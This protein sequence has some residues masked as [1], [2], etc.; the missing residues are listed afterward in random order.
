MKEKILI[1][2]SLNMDIVVSLKNMPGLGET[3]S[4]Y[5]LTYIPGGKGANQAYAAGKLSGDVSMLGCVGNDEFGRI[6]LANLKKAGVNITKLKVSDKNPTGTAIIY[7]NEMGDNSIVIISGANGECDVEYLKENDDLFRWCDYVILQM[8]IPYESVLYSI[9]RANRLE[10][11]IILNPAPAPEELPD[12]ILKML[13][14]ITPNE[15]ELMKLTDCECKNLE[16]YIKASRKLLKRGAKNVLVT[17]GEQGA[18]LVNE[19]TEK[20][21]PARKVESVDTT[22]AG[23]CFNAALT[24]G[25]AD[26]MDEEEAIFFANISSSVA[27]TRKGAQSSLPDRTEIDRVIRNL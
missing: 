24:V 6:Q 22:A 21:Y 27:V 8:E 10:K 16:D 12:D 3:V 4:G 20:V 1:I 13:E 5:S 2:G 15:T 23:D 7:V 11:K 17:L 14:Y 18:L 25:L 26:N 19:K 9:K